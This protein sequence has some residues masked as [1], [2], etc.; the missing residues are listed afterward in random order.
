[1]QCFIILI[2]GVKMERNRC[3]SGRITNNEGITLIVGRKIFCV[4]Q[5]YVQYVDLDC[6]FKLG[7]LCSQNWEPRESSR[8]IRPSAVILNQH[9]CS[10][11]VFFVRS[12]MF[13]C[14]SVCPLFHFLFLCK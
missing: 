9:T 12:V 13:L 5:T 11:Y 7:R 4:S 8:R 6:F 3:L 10:L 14:V 2:D 1:M